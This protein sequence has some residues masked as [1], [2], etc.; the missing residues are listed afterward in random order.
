MMAEQAMQ[1]QLAENPEQ[2]RER[3][4]VVD[5]RGA[6]EMTPIS[7]GALSMIGGLADAASTYYFLKRGQGSE[8]NA[9]LGATRGHPEATALGALGGLAA[10]KGVTAL[11]RKVSP[12]LAEALAANLGA[13]QAAY[14]VT[15]MGLTRSRGGN[16][17]SREYQ[18]AMTHKVINGK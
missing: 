15:N 5:V 14:A 11:V 7:P 1:Q 17:S 10:T 18:N 3:G 6:G 9:L 2:F 12:R 8:G 4:V 16:A 13:L